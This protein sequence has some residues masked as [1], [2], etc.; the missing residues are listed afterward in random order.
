MSASARLDSVCPRGGC[1]ERGLVT[2]GVFS[3]PP[4]VDRF[5]LEGKGEV[6]MEVQDEMAVLDSLGFCVFVIHNAD[7][8]MA[9]LAE[10][11]TAATGFKMTEQNLWKAGERVWNLERIFNIR[12]GFTSKDD[13]LPE[14]LFK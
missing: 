12:E 9:N 4:P 2:S 13:T 5:A 7:I 14:R 1:H 6:A 10:L 11:Y 3:S 8:T